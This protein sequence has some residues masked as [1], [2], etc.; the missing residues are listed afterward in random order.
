MNS[1]ITIEVDFDNNNDPVIQIVSR[2]TD[3]IRDKLIRNFIEKLGTESNWCRISLVRIGNQEAT[4]DRAN[5]WHIRPV[6]TSE[7]EENMSE[8]NAILHPPRAISE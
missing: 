8:M 7:L 6:P 3:D 2:E 5:T 1:R 4:G